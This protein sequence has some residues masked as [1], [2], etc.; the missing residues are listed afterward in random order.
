[1]V[2]AFTGVVGPA[3]RQHPLCGGYDGRQRGGLGFAERRTSTASAL[4]MAEDGGEL[5]VSLLRTANIL[6]LFMA[7]LPTRLHLPTKKSVV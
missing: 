2:S 5:S 6:Y 4:S 3:S 1:M 7:Q